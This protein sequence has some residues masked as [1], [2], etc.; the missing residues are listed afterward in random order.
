M[1]PHT[2][3]QH[4][5]GPTPDSNPASGWGV[6]VPWQ[7]LGAFSV[8]YLQALHEQPQKEVETRSQNTMTAR[9]DDTEYQPQYLRYLG[10]YQLLLIGARSLL[11]TVEMLGNT[12]KGDAISD[13]SDR[14]TAATSQTAIQPTEEICNRG[15]CI[16]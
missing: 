9:Y 6:E 4:L 11:L 15:A 2:S 14:D 5:P 16:D 13:E 3:L 12:G 1:C 7:T 8:P 10:T